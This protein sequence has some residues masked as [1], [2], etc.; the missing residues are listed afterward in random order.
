[1]LEKLN[2]P[3]PLLG[4]GQSLVCPKPA[5]GLFGEDNEF[6]LDFSDHVMFSII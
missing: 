3:Q 1:M 4:L 2:L 6:S 5:A